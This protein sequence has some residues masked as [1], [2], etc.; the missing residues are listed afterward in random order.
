MQPEIS[1]LEERLTILERELRKVKAELKTV[2][3]ET[4]R[5]WWEQLAGQ[6]KND[7]LFDQIVEAGQQYRRSK[8]P[9]TRK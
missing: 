3:K 8:T 9:R 5:P 2:R 6:F 4:Q 1:P 7:P